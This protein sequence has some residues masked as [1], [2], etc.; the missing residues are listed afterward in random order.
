V[1]QRPTLPHLDE[2]LALAKIYVVRHRPG[3]ASRQLRFAAKDVPSG[4]K[5]LARKVVSFAAQL[6]LA[7]TGQ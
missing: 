5:V 3:E 1:G 6:N 7:G 4:D 2:R